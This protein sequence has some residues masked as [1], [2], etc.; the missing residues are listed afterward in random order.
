MRVRKIIRIVDLF[1][2][3]HSW[4]KPW[5]HLSTSQFDI[6]IFSI[7]NNPNYA[8]NT[9]VIG[10][11]LEL[12]Y[13]TIEDHLGGPPDIFYAS[14]PCTTFSIASCGVH[15][16]PPGP[17]DER[18]PK[19]E[20]AVVGLKL[21]HKTIDLVKQGL[22]E[23]LKM[24]YYIENPRG[25]MRKMEIMKPLP[26]HTVW[27]CTYGD[28]R[29]KP[30]DIWTNSDTWIPR[31]V[32]FPGNTNCHHEKAPR[33]SKT[34]TQRNSWNNA[35]RSIIPQRLCI[36]IMYNELYARKHITKA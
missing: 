36:E 28:I 30:T 3:L 7:D 34:G 19:T 17:N 8:N 23:N 2:G 29:A 24:S 4:T 22:N 35:Q 12:D 33:G 21:L 15:W 31:P 27:Y 14:P 13:Q 26:K 32:C 5:K 25:L 18:V 1:S 20:K 16:H 11:L 6:R 10:D 9:T